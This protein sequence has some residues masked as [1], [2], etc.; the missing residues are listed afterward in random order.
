[1]ASK[2]SDQP[3]GLSFSADFSTMVKD[4]Q[5]ASKKIT[6]IFEAA[7]EEG[8]KKVNLKPLAQ[9]VDKQLKEEYKLRQQLEFRLERQRAEA[10]GRLDRA[11]QQVYNR[12]LSLAR[13]VAQEEDDEMKE[14]LEGELEIEKIR[15]RI[16]DEGEDFNE[17]TVK[18]SKALASVLKELQEVD[19]AA[20]K[21]TSAAEETAKAAKETSEWLETSG[22]LFKS[23][24]KFKPVTL[25][26]KA[27]DTLDI[28]A[29][30][31]VDT[32]S[33]GLEGLIGK[34]TGSI[35]LGSLLKGGA[36]TLRSMGES[37]GSGLTK[38]GGMKELG[39]LGPILKSVGSM[40]G[41]LSTAVF[42][43]VGV[44]GIFASVLFDMDKKV[45][46]FN[47]SA[48]TTFGAL[49]LNRLGAGNLN[50]GLLVL[51]RTV[52]NLTANL[53]VSQE[54][55]MSL[56]ETLDKGG[57]T[58]D[59]L[60]GHTSDAVVAQNNLNSTLVALST[61]AKMMGVG[62]AEYA[63]NLTDY[64]N[65]LGMSLDTVN[66]SFAAIADMASRA[67]FG[68]R[69][70]YSMV[71]QATSG[72][73]SLN[74]RLDQTADLLMKMTKI[75]GAKKAAEM[76][77]THAA[78]LAGMG[79]QERTK[80]ALLTGARG[81]R[82]AGRE[83]RSQATNFAVSARGQGAAIAAA[84]KSAGLG[85]QIGQAIA[86]AGSAG[87]GG[88]PN[89]I[90]A[91]S[92]AMVNQ[93][94]AMSTS[95]QSVLIAALESNPATVELGRQMSQLVDISRASSGQL[96][97]MVN[98]MQ[99]FGASGSVAMKLAQLSSVG[100]GRLED[101]TSPEGRMAAENV[102]GLSG[103]QYD[104]MREVSRAVAGQYS[105]LT[106]M[107]P[108]DEAS[109]RQQAEQFGATTDTAGVLRAAQVG[110]DGQ[111]HYLE[112]IDQAN[113][114]IAGYMD[115]SNINLDTIRTEQ[116]AL[117]NDTFDATVSVADILENKIAMYLRSLYENFGVPLLSMVSDLMGKLGVGGVEERKAAAMVTESITAK[118]Q[119]EATNQS[120]NQRRLARVGTEL[121]SATGDKRAA[122][123]AEKRALEQKIADRSTRVEALSAARKRIGSGNTWDIRPGRGQ[124]ELD[125]LLHGN[126]AT[127]SELAAGRAATQARAME[128]MKR[129]A[130]GVYTGAAY[131]TSAPIPAVATPPVKATASVAATATPPPVAVAPSPVDT[132]A[133]QTAAV[134]A[135]VT[136]AST[137]TVAAATENATQGRQ[138]ADRR[139]REGQQHLTR[140]LTRETKLGDAL[141]RS[142]LPDAI[143]EAQLKQQLM[144]MGTA[145][146]LDPEHAASAATQFLTEGTLSDDFRQGLMQHPELSPSALAAGIG[147]LGLTN[148]ATRY[149]TPR[150]TTE[151]DAVE[152]FIYR[153]NG[154]N[155]SIT[156]IDTADQFIGMR[157]GGA[158]D[159]A[160]TAGSQ[161]GSGGTVNINVYGDERRMFDVVKRAL[162][163]SG[164]APTRATANA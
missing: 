149:R 143:V 84:L 35:D 38:L 60:S 83:A 95:Q 21:L 31:F 20:E 77:G 124:T 134:S 154:A 148:A 11:R 18:A 16:F 85:P 46:E 113:D 66:E 74:V 94:K 81:A 152:D 122:L 29:D 8:F 132:N 69:R 63:Q 9:R 27:L 137:T 72:Q 42:G 47:K 142:N 40:V 146:G 163:A 107:R 61:T 19:K 117:M 140:L 98:G 162:R 78:D 64:V 3:Y 14:R 136:A 26:G 129:R 99:A 160:M 56:F 116:S 54:D 105:I 33:S 24:S 130:S 104:M 161:N 25:F 147:P 118:L 45:K 103:P 131:G 4:A 12:V 151:E 68:T 121:Q 139:H 41:G 141:A 133:T 71:V 156:P 76:V 115:R 48:V 119:E 32:I 34:L 2:K 111:I 106:K 144:A 159:R 7:A 153:G 65:D 86:A 93:L 145:A 10:E 22:R 90:S 82:I 96:G 44:F 5:K 57:F 157:P 15:G 55:A 155:G 92:G 59:R 112:R 62:V 114:L 23:L 13:K 135:A 158:I 36:G 97:D 88:D 126:L 100:L 138:D 120:L 43:L 164:I 102:T 109:R 125:T 39:R 91:T 108:T 150:K 110:A 51:N 1:M 17:E 6:E 123:V 80:M 73:S 30:K 52:M 28:G 58:L 37:A 89:A 53:G 127:E 75:L 79:G 87:V 50:R 67:S 70:F 128:D 101:I 49:S